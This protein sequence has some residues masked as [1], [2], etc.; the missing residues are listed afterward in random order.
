MN[1][2]SKLTF[3]KNIGSDKY[4]K[5]IGL[6]KCECGNEKEISNAY[7]K[8][9]HT[10]SCGCLQSIQSPEKLIGNKYGFLTCLEYVGKMAD[11]THLGKFLCECG[12]T[13][14]IKIYEVLKGQVKSCGCYKNKQIGE[15]A[16]THGLSKHPLYNVWHGIICRCENDKHKRYT[17]YGGR[18][19]K[20]CDEWRNDFMSFY[21]WC[22][23]NGWQNG[24]EVDKDIKA[25]KAGIEALL[26]S[27]EWCSIV[28]P[29]E[30]GN[31]TSSNKY[32]QYNGETLT[33]SQWARKLGIDVFLIYRRLRRGW[34]I[35]E[36]FSTPKRIINYKRKTIGIKYSFGHIN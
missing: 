1:G 28:S 7:V 27:P 2:L 29:I 23:E 13:K 9:G 10:K 16:K 17:D 21:K 34:G 4:G 33:A 3:I 19:V 20:I 31:A 12:N 26:Y 6:Y 15:F 22:I 36:I 8:S 5:M 11:G 25:K 18:G 14:N 32:I 30:N 35:E 24:L